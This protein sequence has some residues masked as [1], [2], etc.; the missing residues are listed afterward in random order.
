MMLT[1][2]AALLGLSH[3]ATASDAGELKVFILAGQR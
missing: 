3:T 2:S 1:L